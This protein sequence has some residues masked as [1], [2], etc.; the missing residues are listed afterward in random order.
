MRQANTLEHRKFYKDKKLDMV[1][2]GDYLANPTVCQ[3]ATNEIKLHDFITDHLL[4]LCYSTECE[5]CFNSMEALDQFI[6]DKP[7]LN[8]LILI[9]TSPDNFAAMKDAFKGRIE[10]IYL[11][12][13]DLILHELRVFHMPKGLALNKFGQILSITNCSDQYWFDVL[14]RPLRRMLPKEGM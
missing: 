14:I 8:I 10:Q 9:H 2:V 11:V 7:Y 1:R 12:P 5:T 3:D 4:V 6:D 13:K